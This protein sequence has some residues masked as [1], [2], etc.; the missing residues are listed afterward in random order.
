MPISI[1]AAQ[2]SDARDCGRI[3]HAAFATIADQHSF[4]PDFPSEDVGAGVAAMLIAH[5]GFYG[6]VAEDEGAIVGSNFLDERSN[7]GG[8][9]PI[10]VEPSSQNGGIGRQLMQAVLERATTRKMPGVRLVQDAYHNRSLCLYTSLGFVVREPL[11]VMQGTPLG[12]AVPGY[13]V[14]PQSKAIRRLQCA[15][16]AGARLRPQR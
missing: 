10:T 4:P 7:V 12:L 1:R 5:P 16:P 14:R 15:V 9:G 2:E 6:V 13:D 3:I 8:I 11:S